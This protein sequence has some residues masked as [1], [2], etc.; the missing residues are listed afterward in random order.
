MNKSRT[1]FVGNIPYDMSETQLVDI[2]SEVG[3]VTGFRLVFDRDTGKAK[4]Y[5]FCS[6]T[7]PETAAS[8]VRNLNNYDVGGRQLRVDYAELDKEVDSLPQRH[9]QD[10]KPQPRQT[11]VVQ[12]PPPPAA[13]IYPPSTETIPKIVQSIPPR[14]LADVLSHLKMMT[15]SNAEQTRALL[16]QQPQL[17]FAIFQALLSMNLIDPY[18]A[19]RILQLQQPMQQPQAAVYPPAAYPQHAGYPPTAYPAPAVPVPVAA[20]AVG[21]NAYPPAQSVGPD[22][23][24]LQ[25]QQRQLVMQIMSL[26]PEQIS[27]L[28]ADQQ[29]QVLLLRA[30]VGGGL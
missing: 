17:S 4:G 5:G 11:P 24:H 7:D 6:F 3:T 15:Q 23:A 18:T 14:E 26:T 29:Q 2:F 13:S 22:A 10:Y 16:M 30:Q 19:Q 1:I 12:P 20:P 8:A 28:P 27:Q 9:G 21:A 25:E